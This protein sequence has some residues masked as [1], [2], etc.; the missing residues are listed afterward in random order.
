MHRIIYILLIIVVSGC[1]PSEECSQAYALEEGGRY[2]RYMK[3]AEAWELCP[4]DGADKEKYRFILLRGEHN[5]IIATV[6]KDRVRAEVTAVRLDGTGNSQ[7]GNIT[8]M[9]TKTLTQ[10]EFDRFKSLIEAMDFWN[11]KT[12]KQLIS[13][14]SADAGGE[15]SRWI[16]EGANDN[17]AH[18]ADR[19]SNVHGTF[20]EAGQLLL[21]LAQIGLNGEVY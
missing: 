4:T 7:P 8:E 1:T 19:G 6:V 17:R 15:E 9:R 20:R 12:R 10:E 2:E 3:A 13:A 5:P 11:L 21:D 16:L 14:G 18:A